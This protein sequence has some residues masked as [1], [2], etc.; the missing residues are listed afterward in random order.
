MKKILVIKAHPRT[1][2]FCNALTDEYIK[3]AK[4]GNHD[5]K[6]LKLKDLDLEKFIKHKHLEYP[7]LSEDLLKSQDLISWSEHLVFSYPTW[8]ATPPALLKV[9]LET[10]FQ[11]DFAYKYKESKGFAPKWDKLLKGKSS[12]LI[13]T[14]D[15]PP[16]YYKIFAG[17]PGFKMMKDVLKFCG[18][19]PIKKNYFG[20][21]KLSSEKKRKS[22][23]KKAYEIGSHE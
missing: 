7:N 11:P 21:V 16:W 8:W 18:I 22:W 1:D 17:D 10:I 3:G 2:S 19:K 12:R 23:L 5:I 9:F 6:I 15:G 14:M 13:V 20:S 4:K